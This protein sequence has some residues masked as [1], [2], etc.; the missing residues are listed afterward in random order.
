VAEE[1]RLAGCR[2]RPLASYLKALGLLRVVAR[3]ADPE[4]KARWH[5][6]VLELSS[7]L[8]RP[9][10]SE[11]LLERYAPSPIVSPWNSGAGFFPSKPKSQRALEWIEH[12]RAPRFELLAETI[13]T[14]RAILAEHGL[15][16]DLPKKERDAKLKQAKH[17]IVAALRARC[18]DEAVEWIDAAVV[19]LGA[20]LAFPQALG[21]SGGLDGNFDF[22][23][24]FGQAIAAT[25]A[26]GTDERSR[27]LLAGALDGTQASL[28]RLSMG[29]VFR[30]DSPVNSPAGRADA[31][32]NPWDLILAV[33]GS[34]VLVAGAART[35]GVDTERALV[36]PFSARPTAAGYGSAVAG[37]RGKAELW[38]P[39]WERWTGLIELETLVREARAQVGRRRAR[40]G[41]DFVRAAG[42]LGVARGIDAFERFV[43][44][45]RSGQSSLAVP[46]G[47]IDVRPR[48]AAEA[49]GSI[50]RWLG[51]VLRYAAGDRPA[52]H[53]RAIRALERA[54]FTFA[55]DPCPAGAGVVL[56]ALGAVE[57][58]LA[59]AGKRATD[60]GLAPL[61]FAPAAPWLEA[62]E[63]GSHELEVASALASLRGERLGGRSALRDYLHGT[64]VDERGRRRYPDQSRPAAPRRGSALNRLAAIH[65]ARDRELAA[66]D[67]GAASGVQAFQ[68]GIRCA[69]GSARLL[70]TG[71]LDEE[72]VVRLTGGLALLDFAKARRS[73][74]TSAA[75]FPVPVFDL[76]ALAWQGPADEPL[77]PRQGWAAQLASGGVGQVIADACLRLRLARRPPR[78]EASDLHVSPGQGPRLT[79]ALLVHLLP[80]DREL[81]TRRLT[82]QPAMEG[83]TP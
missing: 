11:F 47:R 52:A 39:M 76:L 44:L 35:H 54:L 78:L 31:L 80:G 33:E 46:V 10:L 67:R 17:D 53:R 29:Y 55:D 13:S 38:L 58:T 26:E 27:E 37:E 60:A 8:D 51:Q 62:A 24:N 41:L 72:R 25:L 5:A 57:S 75:A 32:G 3:Q 2:S 64:A 7:V 19:V 73:P 69:L 59:V 49:I 43:V 4:A 42:G 34:L 15:T 45:E 18:P 28:D 83:A 77:A 48:P 66:N 9:A 65:V 56:E 12:S 22:A 74:S 20:D 79:A 81:L 82:D 61:A 40:S 30:D 68:W 23:G 36:S 70:V 63:D 1:L 16:P 50:D 6:G 14:A 21:G 71:A